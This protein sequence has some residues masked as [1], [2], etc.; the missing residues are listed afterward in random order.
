MKDMAESIA[1]EEKRIIRINPVVDETDCEDCDG[2]GYI[3][4]ESDVRICN[5][6][7]QG[8]P[9]KRWRA[10][11]DSVKIVSEKESR[12][13]QTIDPTVGKIPQILQAWAA[14]RQ[15]SG[16]LLRG[17]SGSGKTCAAHYIAKRIMKTHGLRGR[18]IDCRHLSVEVSRMVTNEDAARY[19]HNA[20]D[21][22]LD[23]ELVLVID[24]IG[25]EGNR[26]STIQRIHDYIN[27]R[28]LQR[29]WTIFTSNMNQ[30][31][32]EAHYGEIVIQRC[33]AGSR[34]M[35]PINLMGENLRATMGE[36]NDRR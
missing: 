33:L 9:L 23:S 3:I 25:G 2:N 12:I 26:A 18:F 11:L 7:S 34:W 5:C 6:R 16:V 15:C 4:S 27:E 30:F 17:P 20:E 31:E 13:A 36:N 29:S 22:V 21:W 35:F 8:Q 24:D 14:N 10:Y 1:N 19:V 28:F 32:L